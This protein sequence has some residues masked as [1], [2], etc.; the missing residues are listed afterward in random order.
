[1]YGGMRFNH[2]I[3][4]RGMFY[5]DDYTR[6]L[7]QTG[8]C[9]VLPSPGQKILSFRFHFYTLHSNF[10][11]L[12]IGYGILTIC[13]CTYKEFICYKRSIHN[14]CRTVSLFFISFFWQ[15]FM[16][17]IYFVRLSIHNIFFVLTKLLLLMDVIIL[18]YNIIDNIC[19]VLYYKPLFRIW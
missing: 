17:L 7:F 8:T 2:R 3:W 15:C 12:V 5:F 4:C 11:Q 10:T 14:L 1:M 19:N 16:L 18:D 9:W 6:P 13:K